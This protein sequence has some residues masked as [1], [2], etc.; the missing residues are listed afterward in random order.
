MG[1]D[2][3]QIE[4]GASGGFYIPPNSSPDYFD[5][6]KESVDRAYNTNL[7]DIII[8]GDFN[9]D[10]SQNNNNKMT[11]LLLEYNL[12]Q[13]ITEPTHFTETSSLI[14]LILVRNNNNNVLNSGVADPFMADYTRYHR[15]VIILLKFTRPHTPWLAE[16][17][18]F[19]HAH[20]EGSGKTVRMSH[21]G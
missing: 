15:P 14:D 1:R 10:M 2:P 17:T 4:K 6:I 19:L 9:I 3:N 18:R 11:D 7:A 20:N 16:G 8:T 21:F 12:N 13:L 5:L